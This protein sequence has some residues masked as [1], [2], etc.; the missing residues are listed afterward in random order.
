MDGGPNKLNVNA[1]EFTISREQSNVQS[2][3]MFS[4]S[5]QFL[6][7]SKSNG[8]IQQQLQLAAAR[9]QMANQMAGPRIL[10]QHPLQMQLGLRVSGPQTPL[11]ANGQSN[12]VSQPIYVF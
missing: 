1:P 4:G 7:H 12:A 8:N 5:N 2:F 9:R 11:S 3:G 6:Q 10:V